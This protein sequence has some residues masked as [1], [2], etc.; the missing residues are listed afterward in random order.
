MTVYEP[1]VPNASWPAA[2][3]VVVSGLARH[4]AVIF[5]RPF[6]RVKNSMV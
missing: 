3:G 1:I 5:Y 4:D 2:T 6:G